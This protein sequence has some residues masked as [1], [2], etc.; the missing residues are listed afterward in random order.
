MFLLRQQE[1]DAIS[2]G[3]EHIKFSLGITDSSEKH[4]YSQG[5]TANNIASLH[6]LLEVS[7]RK[8]GTSHSYEDAEE[9]ESIASPSPSF[10]HPPMAGIN[11]PCS[12]SRTLNFKLDNSVSSAQISISSI[13]AAALSGRSEKIS[14]LAIE[15]KEHEQSHFNPIYT[16][17]W[18]LANSIAHKYRP[19]HFVIG[20]SLLRDAVSAKNQSPTSRSTTRQI[21]FNR[22]RTSGSAGNDE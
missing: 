16:R 10:D 1:L 17:A 7:A 5:Q 20:K 15:P 22:L 13:T 18:L 9:N 8:T 19:I 21:N 2:T 12:G 14:F 3:Y 4:D 11:M 6:L